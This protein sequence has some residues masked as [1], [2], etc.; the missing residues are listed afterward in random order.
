M[1]NWLIL[2]SIL[3]SVCSIN[4]QTSISGR[5]VNAENGEP[6]PYASINF[7]NNSQLLTN[8][9]GSFQLE[10][11]QKEIQLNISYV[12][13]RSKTVE[14]SN[15]VQY[16]MIK[17]Q[18]AVEQLQSVVLSSEE[19]P[20]NA[21]IR[22]A[23]ANKDQNDPQRALRHFS[24]KTY[25]KFLIDNLSKDM[26]L[27]ADTSNLEME[28][29]INA[30]RAFLSEKVSRN[31]Y[32]SRKG[33]KETVLGL[34]NA[35]FEEPVYEVLSLKSNPLSLYKND[36]KLF[37][38]EYA[39]PL[40]DN[41][42]KNYYY[43]I[44]DTTTV[45]RPAYVIY[46]EP[47]RQEAVAG[48]EGLLYLDTLSYAIQQA[49]AQLLGAIKLEVNHYYNYHP[50]HDL[51]FPK[52]QVT[53]IRPGS[54][55]KDI[56]VFGGLIS[57][58]TLQRKDNILNNIF[59]GAPGD[60]NAY[61]SSTSTNYDIDLKGFSPIKTG[62][63]HIEVLPGVEEQPETFWRENRQEIFTQRDRNTA[64]LVD[65]V[66]NARNIERK[67]EVKKAVGNGYY[68]LSF[69]D[70]SL[71]N[72]LKYNR[73]EGIKIGA[74]GKTNSR[75]SNSFNLNGYIAYGFK[76]HTFKYS[77][78]S[79]IFLNKSTGT[80]LELTYTSEIKEFGA[81]SYQKKVNDFS[82]LQPRYSNITNFYDYENL[83][84]SLEHRF[85]SS[86]ETE[87]TVSRSDI[88]MND[89]FDY[90][91]LHEGR[92]YSEYQLAE[93][94]LSF[95]WQ[96]FS[97]FLHTP[98]DYV[99]IE[100][101]FPRFTAQ[102]SHAFKDI[103]EGDF[104]FSRLGL[105]VDYQIRRLDQSR[106]EFILEGNYAFGELP[107]THTFHASPNNTNEYEILNRFAVAGKTSFETMYFN[108]FYSDRQA[109]LNIRHQLRPFYFTR[110]IQPNLVIVSRFAIGDF[111][112]KDKHTDSDFK[113][114][115]HGFS[116]VGLELNNIFAGF[117]L[118]TAY[119][120]G[121]Y[122]LPDFEDNISLK[123]SFQLQL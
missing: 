96:P 19:N 112:N 28:T 6:L 121:A 63:A 36:Y 89:S 107:L 17:L 80:S 23:I 83:H 103:A 72:L 93:A 73:Y 115:E 25:T 33:L 56:S 20:A 59:G 57:V 38:T 46:F 85:T 47:R 88:S 50:E 11:D 78:G 114:M 22:R 71:N 60:N 54:G 119:R 31:S 102:F 113:V 120:Y 3:F 87:I 7:G 42:F 39:G 75:F 117:G 122:H 70:L 77:L 69:W 14:I 5:I 1:S 97:K 108:E 67:L 44:L 24:Y 12:G 64:A 53:T 4:A 15:A 34:E 111:E 76:D 116:E 9:D 105:R 49:K 110:S 26:R 18:P 10:Y 68:P 21:I 13:F 101:G 29:I 48:L 74:G 58:G 90:R 55:G 66:I 91:Y 52:K 106:T 98:E 61:L 62:A 123:F 65:S 118:T 81:F 2:L 94:G 35:G 45:E 41:S 86:L 99:V 51:W 8:I 30:G 104:T 92:V 100:H 32:N 40:A 79:E 109:M 82:I 16:V 27:R 95:L 84:A 37:E 43:T